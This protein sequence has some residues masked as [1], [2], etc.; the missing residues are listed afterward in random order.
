M[1]SS[2]DF[3]CSQAETDTCHKL[4]GV[5]VVATCPGLV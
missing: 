5:S 2:D 4:G 1:Y 3:R